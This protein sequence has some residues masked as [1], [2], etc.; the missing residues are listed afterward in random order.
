M[1]VLIVR[2]ASQGQSNC[3]VS[4]QSGRNYQEGIVIYLVTIMGALNQEGVS[5]HMEWAHL[6]HIP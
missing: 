2:A 1:A 6:S 3:R 5:A 4:R